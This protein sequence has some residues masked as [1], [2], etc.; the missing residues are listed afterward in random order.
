M[1]LGVAGWK[2]AV[3]WQICNLPEG[4]RGC[5]SAGGL[6]EATRRLEIPL[7]AVDR[8]W[9][10]LASPWGQARRTESRL[11][12]TFHKLLT[13]TIYM[14]TEYCVVQ[15]GLCWA[16]TGKWDSHTLYDQLHIYVVG[17][18]RG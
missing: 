12:F 13:S 17:K 2:T 4:P 7:R 11:V 5:R 16:C 14:E 18:G 1:W 6:A 3:V 9:I 15:C 10:H 8:S